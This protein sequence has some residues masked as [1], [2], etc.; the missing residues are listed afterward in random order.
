MC[1]AFEVLTPKIEPKR[2]YDSLSERS[3]LYNKKG[4]TWVIA[5]IGGITTVGVTA[6]YSAQVPDQ[7]FMGLVAILAYVIALSAV[8]AVVAPTCTSDASRPWYLMTSLV[9]GVAAL[10]AARTEWPCFS[11]GQRSLR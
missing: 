3:T 1:L 11:C 5:A 6:T 4:K 9:V 8:T 7:A 10:A 2:I